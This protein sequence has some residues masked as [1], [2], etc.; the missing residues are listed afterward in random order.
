[1]SSSGAPPLLTAEQKED[2]MDM[3]HIEN[4]TFFYT[5][6]YSSS[7]YYQNTA[8]Q[9]GTIYGIDE[10]YLDTCGYMIQSGRGLYRKIMTNSE[11]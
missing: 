10:N 7:V 2:V 11:K 4:A 6:T 5:R 3:E 9:G 8:F 1:M